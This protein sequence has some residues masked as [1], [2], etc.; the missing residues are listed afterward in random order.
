[1]DKRINLRSRRRSN[2]IGF[3]LFFFSSLIILAGYLPEAVS[4]K[5]TPFVTSDYALLFTGICMVILIS[6]S[7]V[8]SLFP[9]RI[10]IDKKILVN[11]G[12]IAVAFG[13]TGIT[14]LVFQNQISF[15]DAIYKTFQLFVGEFGDISYSTGTFPLLLNISRFLALFVTFGAITVLVLR[16][17]ISQLN[18]R[19]FY[20]DVVIFTD[21]I[22]KRI[23]ALADK[24]GESGRKIVIGLIKSSQEIS[25]K[26]N[27]SVPVIEFDIDKTL[28]R[29]LA[30]CNV[31]HAKCIYLFCNNTSDNII[32]FR[33]VSDQFSKPGKSRADTAKKEDLPET[34]DT[35]DERLENLYS[36][37]ANKYQSSP[38]KKKR[39]RKNVKCFIQYKSYS[40]KE[41]YSIDNSL[42]EKSSRLETYFI[43][44]DINALRQMIS[45][46][47][48]RNL[49]NLK[50]TKDA[51]E[52]VKRMNSLKIGIAGSGILLENTAFEI[53]RLCTFSNAESIELYYVGG[54]TGAIKLK[55]LMS[56]SNIGDSVVI[57]EANLNS[58]N[59]SIPD[60]DL[61]FICSDSEIQIKSIVHS[62]FQMGLHSHIKEMLILTEGNRIEFDILQKYIS[63]LA[64][65]YPYSGGNSYSTIY[66][67]NSVDLIMSIDDFYNAYGPD[68]HS[69]HESYRL[70]MNNGLLSDFNKLPEELIESNLLSS[71]H[72]HL[73]LGMLSSLFPDSEKD[74]IPKGGFIEV[75]DHLAAVEH[76]RWYRER[77]M[78]GYILSESHDYLLNKNPYLK[79][80]SGLDNEMKQKNKSYL[81]NAIKM[82]HDKQIAFIHDVFMPNY[83]KQLRYSTEEGDSQDDI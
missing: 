24:I 79:H 17:K 41:Y 2:F 70:A 47:N 9:R 83:I 33:S 67:G 8:I 35:Y 63:N 13:I 78:Q 14:G 12:L 61:L 3:I 52:I 73:L 72:K 7:F 38:D 27:E 15:V 62:V 65:N 29:G 59:I 51:G 31:S 44:P 81:I 30:Y 5:D 48:L 6:S 11:L 56:N 57:N 21:N 66:I 10:S 23:S 39:K 45:G 4:W 36:S 55:A 34:E 40:E 25:F 49:L 32:L 37:L 26:S 43:N 75:I 54:I 82:Q 58:K 77:L 71:I 53:P 22:D 50:D 46:I 80:W 16:E 19:L 18:I 42:A 64:G 69:V 20:R 28:L 76:E 68:I 74:I 1:M 60:L